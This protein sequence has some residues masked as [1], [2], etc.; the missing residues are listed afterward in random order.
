M[1]WRKSASLDRQ[2][3][4]QGQEAGRW[5]KLP[6]VLAKGAQHWRQSHLSSEINQDEINHL[7]HKQSTANSPSAARLTSPIF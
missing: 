4:R 7:R 1:P 3:H 2:R 6:K 5:Q